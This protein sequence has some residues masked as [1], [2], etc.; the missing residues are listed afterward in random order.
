MRVLQFAFGNDAK[1]EDYR[2]KNYPPNCVVY[3]GTHDNDTTAGW[4]WSEAGEGS[5][6]SGEEIERER[7]MILE[8]LDR[9]GREIHWDMIRL[10]LHSNAN[11]AIVPLQDLL[12]LGSEGRMNVPGRP[13]GNWQWRFTW[14]QVTPD[15]IERMHRL[16]LDSKRT[17]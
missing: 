2:P 13:S 3:T 12:G 11:M 6:R 4:F 9:D 5:T 8:H 10:A 14:D 16:T 17:H 7:Q 1:A 15:I